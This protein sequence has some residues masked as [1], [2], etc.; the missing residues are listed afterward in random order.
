MAWS[1]IKP[2]FRT[3]L[4]AQS[5][6]EWED[7]FAF[8]NIPE[9]ILDGAY[10]FTF[11]EITGDTLNHDAQETLIPITIRVF[12][13]GFRDPATGIDESVTLAQTIVTESVKTSTR[14]TQSFLNIS[15]DTVSILPIAETNDNAILI[16]LNFTVRDVLTI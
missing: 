6:S 3:V 7:G 11:G 4:D 15:F 16:E 8:E 13:K 5:L 10:H 2:Y 14:I 12:K 1:D 9:T